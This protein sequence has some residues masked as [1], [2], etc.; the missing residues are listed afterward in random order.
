MYIK[1]ISRFI[2]DVNNDFENSVLNVLRINKSVYDDDA[3]EQS[4]KE[5][6]PV[7]ADVLKELPDS[8]RNGCQIVLEAKAT[9]NEKMQ[10]KG[11][12]NHKYQS[13]MNQSPIF[14]NDEREEMLGFIKIKNTYGVLLSRGE[15]GCYI[16][17]YDKKLQDYLS[18]IIPMIDVDLEPVENGRVLGCVTY[19][20]HDRRFA[21]ITDSNGQKYAVSTNTYDRLNNPTQT[22]VKDNSVS[23]TVWI[24]EQGKKYANDVTTV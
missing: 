6:L 9:A 12:F 8:V 5:S 4:W 2:E 11:P 13:L 7:L 24:S 21:Y 20:D 18:Q 17:C 10:H 15:K 23:F 1:E 3:E 16:Y 22:L 14:T 19:V